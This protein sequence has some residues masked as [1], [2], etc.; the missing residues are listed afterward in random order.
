MLS[1]RRGRVV[2]LAR[3]AKGAEGGGAA[4]P[5]MAS[6][7][8]QASSSLGE[9]DLGTLHSALYPARNS[10]KSLGLQLGV[11]IGEVESIESKYTDPGERLLGILRA[12]MKK[13]E[14]L[15][16]ND[17]DSALRLDCVDEGKTADD[18]RKKYRHLFSLDPT[19][20]EKRKE[21]AEKETRK[22]DKGT[23]D[24]RSRDRGRKERQD[25]D[26]D[27][28]RRD[29][30]KD[31]DQERRER[32]D[33]DRD[34]GR[35]E[36][37]DED[38][39][40]GRR[41]GEDED[42]DRRRS[43]RQD[44]DWDRKRRERQDEDGDRRRRERQDEDWD[45][46]RRERQDE[47]RDRG[48]RERQ[49]DYRDRGRRER[50][51]EDLDRGRR[52]RQDEDK[53][54]GTRVR[55]EDRSRG[56]RER[57]DEDR[58]RGR[59][60]RQDEDWDRRRRDR[61]D[62]DWD[63]GRRERQDEDRDRGRRDRQDEDRRDKRWD[64][65]RRERHNED[66]ESELESSEPEQPS[67]DVQRN[68]R[69]C[70]V[71]HGEKYEKSKQKVK[72]KAKRKAVRETSSSSETDNSSPECDGVRI[73]SKSENKKLVSIF[74]CAYGK[75]CYA[76]KD[77]NEMAVQLQAK[78]MLS[79]SEMEDIL[80]SPESQQVKAISLVRSLYR[81]IK[82]RPNKVF[83]VSEIFVKNKTLKELGR[84]ISFEIGKR[85]IP[86]IFTVVILVCFFFRKS[87]S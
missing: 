41:E 56:R 62:E 64:Q 52:D 80:K 73:L 45:R 31:R 25:E 20:V 40:R 24:D 8:D 84:E 68:G 15:T 59:R 57:Q 72:K 60:E 46:K 30:D 79:R 18:I 63:R 9:K 22:N 48:R 29:R 12:R 77:P 81:K 44:E 65:R 10:Y 78:R 21:K 42:W 7:S 50:Q 5:A 6:G 70:A 37:Q 76:I 75:L 51:D 74:K 11:K 71:D 69:K 53:D 58:D 16:W 36:R 66:R 39:D 32:Q 67:M 86:V 3:R 55:H 28:G 26:W 4:L 85:L 19:A 54:R 33:E 87:L 14:P 2:F 61:Q 27:R 17:I 34:R 43:E 49:D 83:T 1:R 38:W 82:S 23:V 13:A 35:R 47:D